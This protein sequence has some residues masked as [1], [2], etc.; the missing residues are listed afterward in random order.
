MSSKTIEQVLEKH[1]D[2]LMRIHGVVGTGQGLCDGKPC[3]KIF[4]IKK[5]AELE[6]K[7]P[8]K[9]EGHLVM[10]EETGEI[11]ALPGNQK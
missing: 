2:I 1:T 7:I 8:R 4:V 6:K 9:L 11:H 3:I 5:T 10:V